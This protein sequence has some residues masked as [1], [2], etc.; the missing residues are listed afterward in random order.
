MLPAIFQAST[1]GKVDNK[2]NHVETNEEYL[3]CVQEAK[4]DAEEHLHS[5]KIQKTKKK[6]SKYT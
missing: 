5:I 3:H 4:E 2:K 6:Q 1:V